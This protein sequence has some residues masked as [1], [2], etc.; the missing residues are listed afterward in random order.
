MTETDTV[1][2]PSRRAEHPIPVSP[3]FQY[4]GPGCS[5]FHGIDVHGPQLAGDL[6]YARTLTGSWSDP[7]LVAQGRTTTPGGSRDQPPVHGGSGDATGPDLRGKDGTIVR[8]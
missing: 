8:Y 2:R 4:A 5:R 1:T 3:P 7:S 6:P